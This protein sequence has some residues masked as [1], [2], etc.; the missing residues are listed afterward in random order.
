MESLTEDQLYKKSSH[1]LTSLLYQSALEKLEK[2]MEALDRKDYGLANV[3]LQKCNDILYRLGAGINYEAGVMAEQLDALYNYMAEK[4]I[5]GN[6][7]KDKKAIE[8]VHKLLTI[9]ADAWKTA[10][11]NG[12][13]HKGMQLRSKTTAY[14]RNLSYEND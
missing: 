6:Y 11:A 2:A 13:S 14:E 5:Q 7:N 10:N 3:L 8:E 9:I 1:E 4:L 12:P